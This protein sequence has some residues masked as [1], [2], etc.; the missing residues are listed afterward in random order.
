V[1]KHRPSAPDARAFGS[2]GGELLERRINEVD[3][4]IR[5]LT[6]LKRELVRLRRRARELPAPR[7]TAGRYCHI[8]QPA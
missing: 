3:G 6:R 7:R 1:R 4:T 8:L 5:E 2:R